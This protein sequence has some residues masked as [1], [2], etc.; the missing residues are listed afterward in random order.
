MVDI[1][2]RKLNHNGRCTLLS[3]VLSIQFPHSMQSVLI[4]CWAPKFL[5]NAPSL[6]FTPTAAEWVPKQVRK[7][8][9][10]TVHSA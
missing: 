6:P 8:D 2:R 9:K 4:I 1:S 3:G 7:D 10:Q 5:F